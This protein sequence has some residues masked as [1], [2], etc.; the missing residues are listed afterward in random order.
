MFGGNEEHVRKVLG[1]IAS[2]GKSRKRR[3]VPKR[4]SDIDD[5]MAEAQE[6][7]TQKM[8]SACLSVV[9]SMADSRMWTIGLIAQKA[10]KPLDHFFFCS[11]SSSSFFISRYCNMLIRMIILPLVGIF[12]SKIKVT[13]SCVSLAHGREKIHS[14]F[15]HQK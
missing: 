2:K 12:A 1:D 7:Y 5:A 4:S 10:R 15:L 3:P 9:T 13:E 8:S 11:R 14:F 6:E